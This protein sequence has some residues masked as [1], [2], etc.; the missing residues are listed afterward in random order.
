MQSPDSITAELSNHFI[1]WIQNLMYH[2]KIMTSKQK[3][4]PWL[5]PDHGK[6]TIITI[7]KL[8]EKLTVIYITGYHE[9]QWNDTTLS[10]IDWL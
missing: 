5:F 7:I 8:F 1:A 10:F 4:F 6:V 3:S 2:N 9:Q